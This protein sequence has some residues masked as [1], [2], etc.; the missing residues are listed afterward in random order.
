[1]RMKSL[2][3]ALVMV[4]TAA[5]FAQQRAAQP[6]DVALTIAGS[7]A[8]PDGTTPLLAAVRAGDAT[9]VA[10]LIKSGADVNASNKYGVSPLFEAAEAGQGA[11]VE[12]LVKAGADVNAARGEGQTILMTAARSGNA[13][14]VKALIEHG[15]DV[16][17]K[18]TWFG[19]TPVM[20]AAAENHPDVIKLLAGRGA[21][22]NDASTDMS[23]NQ[24]RGG[25]GGGGAKGGFTAVAFAARNGSID[26]LKALADLG[27][28]LNKPDPDGITPLALA[29]LSGNYDAAKLLIERGADVNKGDRTNRTPLYIAADMKTLQWRFNRPAPPP[30]DKAGT[31]AFDIVK[32]LLAHGADVNV[33]LANNIIAPKRAATGNSNLSAGSTPFLKAAS[34]SDLEL[35][36]YLLDWGA[37]PWIT[38]NIHTN[39][40][41]M[42]AGL[43]WHPVDMGPLNRQE[44]AIEAAKLLFGLGFDVNATNDRGETALH[45]AASRTEDKEAGD[46]VMF[47]V[48]HGAN[49]YARTKAGANAGRG[50]AG[51]AQ[52]AQ[53]PQAGPPTPQRGQLP[54]DMALGGLGDTDANGNPSTKP[55]NHK[56]VA[57][58]EKLMKERPETVASNER[59]Q[60][61]Q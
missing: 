54:I 51:G 30:V 25:G 12:L 49:L 58:L 50:G 48:D 60:A 41:M 6:N 16:N 34:T 19:E 43:N 38:N 61:N 56:I 20:L 59:A 23:Q 42:A 11:I 8:A 46:L 53:A 13:A 14:A 4:A 15:A 24:G 7:R 45:G 21:N 40:L 36:R 44:E 27:A 47:L 55:T 22:I 33:R 26:S 18:E 17:A 9:R 35:M 2:T 28:D 1:M 52:Q 37:D 57:L 29:L 10:A 32:L 3:G 31:S 5:V 39:A